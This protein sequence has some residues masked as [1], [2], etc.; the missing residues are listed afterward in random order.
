MQELLCDPTSEANFRSDA[1]RVPT[2]LPIVEEGRVNK[3]HVPQDQGQEEEPLIMREDDV[4]FVLVDAYVPQ[5]VETQQ[6]TA[7]DLKQAV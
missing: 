3:P 4:A 6:V 1:V 7:K 5:G 2:V